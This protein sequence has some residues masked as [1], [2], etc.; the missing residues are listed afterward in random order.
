M[1]ALRDDPAPRLYQPDRYWEERARQFATEGTGLA[2]V[3]SYGMPD[4]YNRVIHSAQFL[5]LSRWLRPSPG[6]HALDVGCGVGRWSH[7]L[8]ARGARVTGVDLSPTMIAQAERR[9]AAAGLQ[10][11]CR[12]M[13]QDLR[14]LDTG[15]RHDLVL[16]VTVLQHILDP[17][18]LRDALE[19]MVL[20]LA[21]GGRLVLLEAAPSRVDRRCNS[22]VFHARH[23][24]VYLRLFQE[25]GTRLLTMT[26]VDPAPFRTWLLPR[27]PRLSRLSPALARAAIAAAAALSA[28]VD[29]LS[30]RMAVRQ[31]WHVLFVLERA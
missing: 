30:G 26:G 17:V 19:R 28:P 10:D 29:L 25:C 8:A 11:R 3:C 21:P 23:R 6:A 9:A 24:S 18:A 22:Q 12:F 14:R 7:L 13:V 4:L 16:S 5:A 31:S 15:Q 20:H 1:T 27:L 2:A